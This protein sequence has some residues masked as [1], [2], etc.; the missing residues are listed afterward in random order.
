[1]LLSKLTIQV[2]F[3]VNL[4]QKNRESLLD[5]GMMLKKNIRIMFK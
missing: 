2:N 5:N 3:M 4:L 1:M